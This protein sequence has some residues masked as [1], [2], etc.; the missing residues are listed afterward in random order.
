MRSV[1]THP[2]GRH[3]PL[4]AAAVAAALVLPAP[5]PTASGPLG[6]YGIVERVVFEPNDQA[7][8]RVQV[9]G[10]FM[11]VD[12]AGID[13]TTV[14]A[15]K[16]GYLYFRLPDFVP[17]TPGPP[18][19]RRLQTIRNEWTDLRSVAGTGQAVA[20]G[21]WG[22]IAGFSALEPDRHPTLPSFTYHARPGGGGGDASDLRVRPASEPPAG[23]AVYQTNVGV[24]KIPDSGGHAPIVKQLREA[25]KR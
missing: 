4:F 1:S 23:P 22:Y 2:R 9:W 6:I 20:F 21:R 18:E 16:R 12:G 15:A 3:R 8:E 17:G 5:G 13:S 14:S 10:A 25:L 19:G 11:Y 24:V 7:P